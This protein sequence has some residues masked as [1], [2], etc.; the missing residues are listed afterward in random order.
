MILYEVTLQVDPARARAVEEHMRREHIPEIFASGCFH[1]IRFDQ[2]SPARF[3]T[4]Y[5][6]R[7]GSDLERYF[8]EY[9]PRLRADFQSHFPSGVTLTRETWTPLES[10][11]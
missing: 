9:A 1:R 10:W 8:Q 6:A 5:E 7:T 2:A 3:R 4:S 11:R